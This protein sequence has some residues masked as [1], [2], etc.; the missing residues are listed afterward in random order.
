VYQVLV[1]VYEYNLPLAQAQA[2]GRFH[3]QLLPDNVIEYEADKT[4]QAVITDLAARG[5]IPRAGLE[6]GD[7]IEAIQVIED[8]PFPVS[9]PRSN[10]VSRVITPVRK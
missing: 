8:Q 4:P 3:H 10:G 1:D 6:G 2:Q 7:D 9:D 5:W